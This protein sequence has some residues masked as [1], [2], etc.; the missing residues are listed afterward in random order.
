MYA[1]YRPVNFSRF[2]APV[3]LF[4]LR[5][6]PAFALSDSLPEV[7][8]TDRT[9]TDH[10]K[11]VLLHMEGDPLSM[12]LLELRGGYKLELHFDDMDDV[13][14]EYRYTFVHCNADWSP[15]DLNQDE[16]L[17]GWPENRIPT[18]THSFNTL[19]PYT[20]YQLSLP[21][22]DVQ[23]TK[24]G[25][26][27]IKV[28]D[29]NEPERILITRRFM[30]VDR[31]VTVA[32]DLKKPSRLDDMN[33]KQEI[34]FNIFRGSYEIQDPF[35]A[36]KV[37][38]MQNGRWDNAV[39]DMKPLFVK[40]DVLIYDDDTKNVFPGNNE[41]RFFDTKSLRYLSERIHDIRRD[42]TGTHVYLYADEK[43][44]F[45]R[46][47]SQPDINGKFLV[48]VQEGRDAITDA[49]YVHVHFAL[50]MAHP[51]LGGDMYVYGALSDNQ[52]EPAFKMTYNSDRLAYI[53]DVMLKQGYYNYVYAFKA[54]G[55]SVPDITEVEG[56]HFETENDYMILVYD[57]PFGDDYDHLIGYIQFNSLKK[58]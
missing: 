25:N 34:D 31:Q 26:Y 43:R 9:Y 24:S 7:T 2:L 58:L 52:C 44:P 46:Y 36:F 8:M 56:M 32:P 22:D 16:Y 50:P 49:D 35:G 38:L 1:S 33:Y 40:D 28:F 30:I 29:A 5:F 13:F 45:K 51:M 54:K 48:A 37:V 47:A 19:V 27:I 41:Y 10:I 6:T 17:T 39:T 42:S 11:T 57:R 4:V 23:F 21:N 53:L 15:S 12:P 20:H 14:R 18:Y 55:D 3:L